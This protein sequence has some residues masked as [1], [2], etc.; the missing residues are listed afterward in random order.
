MEGPKKKAR[1][2]PQ[3][4]PLALKNKTLKNHFPLL[5]PTVWDV[6]LADGFNNYINYCILGPIRVML[7]IFENAVLQMQLRYCEFGTT[8]LCP[9]GWLLWPYLRD[10]HRAPWWIPPHGPLENMRKRYS[11]VV[12]DGE[13]R[14]RFGALKKWG[15]PPAAWH[16]RIGRSAGRRKARRSRAQHPVATARRHGRRRNRRSGEALRSADG[17]RNFV[18]TVI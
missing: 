6:G 12:N 14:E 18:G 9:S 15:A 10:F 8:M 5:K 17:F 7:K 3:T 1:K 2:I 13:W 16:V 11:P 4:D